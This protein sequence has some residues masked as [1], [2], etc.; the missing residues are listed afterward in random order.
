MTKLDEQIERAKK[1]LEQEKARLSDL[2]QKQKTQAQKDETRRKIIYGA[3]LLRYLETVGSGKRATIL[4][5]IEEHVT[6]TCDEKF[7]AKMRE[8]ASAPQEKFPS[9]SI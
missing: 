5:M 8:Q 1:K 7:L 6:R 2:Q 4:S 9:P 3:A